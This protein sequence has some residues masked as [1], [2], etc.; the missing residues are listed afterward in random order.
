MSF[1]VQMA[2]IAA[3]RSGRGVDFF[4]MPVPISRDDDAYFKPLENLSVR[5]AKVFLVWFTVTTELKEHI[6]GLQRHVDISILSVL[7]LSVASDGGLQ[8]RYPN[9]WKS[10]SRP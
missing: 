2:N 10:T 1:C 8:N 5:D 3:S 4:H 7:R 9:S 6:G